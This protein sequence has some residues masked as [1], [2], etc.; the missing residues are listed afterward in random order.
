MISLMNILPHPNSTLKLGFSGVSFNSRI[1]CYNLRNIRR[2]FQCAKAKVNAHVHP[3]IKEKQDVIFARDFRDGKIRVNR[4][5]RLYSIPQMSVCC[6]CM[7]D[8]FNSSSFYTHSP[9][10]FP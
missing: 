2:F 3:R 10:L 9:V 6:S 8:Q 5:G 1:H 7:C 4:F